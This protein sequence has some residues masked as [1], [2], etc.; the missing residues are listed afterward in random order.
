MQYTIAQAPAMTIRIIR[1]F[2]AF[3]DVDMIE[4]YSMVVMES[5]GFREVGL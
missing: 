5:R 1:G 2:F 4:Y 3:F